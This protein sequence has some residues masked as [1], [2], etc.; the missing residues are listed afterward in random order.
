MS[1]KLGSYSTDAPIGQVPVFKNW[2]LLPPDAN[3]SKA[4]RDEALQIQSKWDSCSAQLRNIVV[5]ETSHPE[6]D[7]DALLDISILGRSI[8]RG[9][10]GL[11]RRSRR[12]RRY[13][14]TDIL[15]VHRF[16]CAFI[17]RAP[18]APP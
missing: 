17:G 13:C 4:Y 18:H 5:L 3:D 10:L 9:R 15:R 2:H 12:S 6:E 14:E 7:R 1:D 16:L 8:D 11:Y